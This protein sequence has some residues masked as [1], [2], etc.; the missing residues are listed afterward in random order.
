MVTGSLFHKIAAAFLKH[1]LPCVTPLKKWQN[2]V[3]IMIPSFF[4]FRKDKLASRRILGQAFNTILV[5][6][7]GDMIVYSQFLF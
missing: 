1:L 4:K 5:V 6:I 7:Y 2:Y 3:K